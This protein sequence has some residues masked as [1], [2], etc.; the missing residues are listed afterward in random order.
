VIKSRDRQS[1]DRTESWML[2]STSRSRPPDPRR[3]V[4]GAAPRVRYH[5]RGGGALGVGRA[6]RPGQ[7]VS[8]PP[9]HAAERL[10]ATFAALLANARGP[11]AR[12]GS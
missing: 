9:A 4:R 6:P 8:R 10:V 11:W 7:S 3:P 1:R 5:P 12:A 2:T